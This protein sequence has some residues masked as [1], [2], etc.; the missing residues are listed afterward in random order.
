MELLS[1]TNT[2]IG[3]MNLDSDISIIT[4][5]Q[6]R[7][8]QNVRLITDADGT[9]GA[10]Q[11]I[12]S[13]RKYEGGLS[14]NETILGTA[15]TRWYNQ[16]KKK[17][18]ECGIVI[19][20][21]YVDNTYYNR[22]WVV[23]NFESIK[24]T[25]KL[26][27]TVNLGI[28]S[29]V[30]IVTN[31]ESASTSNVYF[32]DGENGTIKVVNIQKTHKNTITDSNYF[33]ILQSAVM[34][35]FK[36]KAYTSGQLKAG[37]VQYCYQLF[38][39]HGSES[40]L[41]TVSNMILINSD[42]STTINSVYGDE[43]EFVTNKGCKIQAKLINTSLF[44]RVRII[45]I[46][47]K[48]NTSIPQITVVNEVEIS[49]NI[50][51]TIEY[52]DDGVT[53]IRELTIEQF[54]DIIPNEFCAKSIA[55]L[56]NRLFAANLQD[57]TWDVDYDARAY[58][59]DLYGNVVLNSSTGDQIAS[60]LS[61][62]LSSDSDIII[63]KD[64][65]CINPMNG[66]ITYPNKKSAV[67]GEE[68]A[69]GYQQATD[70]T[71]KIRGGRGINIAY[72]FC[73]I[74]MLESA[75]QQ[76]KPNSSTPGVSYE[77]TINS[78]NPYRTQPIKV[79]CPETRDVITTINYGNVAL[80]NYGNP[81][82]VSDFLSYQRDEIY[83]FGIVFYNNKGIA[84]PV[85]W[86][87]DIRFPSADVKGYEPFTF[88]GSLDGQGKF[89]LTSHPLGIIFE[90]NNLPNEVKAYEIVR[91]N[92][93]LADRTVIAQGL[94]NRTLQFRGYDEGGG[95]DSQISLGYNDIRPCVIPTFTLG[96]KTDW[97]N[98]VISLTQGNLYDDEFGEVGDQKMNKLDDTGIFN[99]VSPEVSFNKERITQ[100]IK[101]GMYIVPLCCADSVT[102]N[103]K[104]RLGIPVT[105]Y[106]D[107]K[108]SNNPFGY[109]YNCKLNPVTHKPITDKYKSFV[110]GLP[111]ES[112]VPT[113]GL[114]RYFR[115][116]KK[117][118]ADTNISNYSN[119]ADNPDRYAFK[120]NSVLSPTNITPYLNDDLKE[121]KNYVQYIED[122]QYVNYF[123]GSYDSYGPSGVNAV[124]TSPD[125]Y[126]RYKGVR[127]TD[128]GN[129]LTELGDNTFASV[130]FCNIKNNITPYGGNTYVARS[131][132][133]YISTGIVNISSTSRS[134][135]FGGDTYLGIYDHANSLMYTKTDADKDNGPKRY[136]GCYIPVE[137]SVNVYLRNDKHFMQEAQGINAEVYY[138]TEPGTLSTKHSQTKPM[139]SYNAAFSAKPTA[140][141]FIAKSIYAE[142][143][144]M[145]LNRITASEVKTN[146]ELTDSW[147]KFKF[148]NY[149][150]TDSQYGQITNLKV[151]KNRLYFFQD[152]SVGV[153]S[154]NDRSLIQ[155]NNAGE[156]VLGTGG[157]L[158]R[159]DYLVVS[160]G[161]S[162]VN[163][164]S[165][166]NS[167][168]TL[169]W[170]DFDKNTICSLGDGFNELSKIKS[171]Q[172]YLNRLP[173]KAK[174]N[175]VS[176]YDKKYNE[177]WF[178]IYDRALIFN[179]QLNVFTS[180]YTHNPNWFFPFSQ[181]LITV[182]DNNCYYLH[183]IYDIQSE[184]QE[185]KI[186][187]IQ[188]IV[189][190]DF[191][192]TKVFDNQWFSADFEDIEESHKQIQSISFKTKDQI[193]DSID[194]NSIENRE[195]T[196]RFPISREKQD[197]K[198]LQQQ[199]NMSYAGRLRGKY[200]VCDYT[201]D[202]NNNREF[203]IPF[204]KTTYRY[205]LI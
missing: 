197:N 50:N 104:S 11:N 83:R 151:F 91:C 126:T 22:L 78:S 108:G 127:G 144:Q 28:S 121:I 20:K 9:T 84:S 145:N 80:R 201:F 53:S 170:F 65:D 122:K 21:A 10:L 102:Y 168:T 129:N 157:V 199:T 178:K 57:I 45:R 66:S 43:K 41:S 196:Y 88:G 135:C 136:V 97:A 85:H 72:R 180:F 191:A 189:N 114:M 1:Q 59:C 34:L 47:Y 169:Y 8:A 98:E 160:N 113:G 99:F 71:Y 36:L 82:F 119:I 24:P 18:E 132:S 161:D 162:I 33:D 7:S 29:K 48:D 149:I 16:D 171:V 12:E 148:A 49:S 134:T 37:F 164:K 25:W 32:T 192:Q 137:S 109:V 92:R 172:T 3:G 153:A 69:F 184:N 105:Y 190:K 19:T 2:F 35:P 14:N 185:E 198:D 158:T 194:Y 55:K 68:F 150:D 15:V 125:I 26:I 100:I 89:E 103:G 176:F 111:N 6:Y 146:N 187:N 61:D 79:Y 204:V 30:S 174:Q 63:P 120:I 193:T 93:T 159:Y 70:G 31:Y 166:T 96:Y 179:E 42:N 186:S 156:L 116:F 200:L 38:N 56:N 155:D 130:L 94:L 40:S 138:T 188:F 39:L 124:I 74:D 5:N 202:C 203:K 141:T 44:N 54:N 139:Y 27:V 95:Y 51:Q 75:S 123:I 64:H 205:S 101:D 90:V 115:F 165:I 87:G 183:N 128:Y 143:N 60:T 17:V 112:D 4:E 167:E 86:I 175:P 13:I 77:L 46:Y 181:K 173:L 154:V 52:I 76:T 62:I 58:R 23:T 131:N 152:S 142:D 106:S 67:T 163:D 107:G 147:T 140:R 133:N 73:T 182:K 177:V 81:S 195:D 117:E 110:D 118:Y